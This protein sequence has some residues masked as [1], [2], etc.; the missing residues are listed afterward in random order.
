[1]KSTDF[2]Q[3]LS[4]FLGI[5]LPGQGG[6]SKNTI[7]SYRDSFTLLLRYCDEECNIS[8]RKIEISHISHTLVVNFLVW[9]E[10]VRN[11]S[12]STRNNR[13]AAIQSFFRYL[14][15]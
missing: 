1:M 14:A 13:L 11:S 10:N 5:Y 9:L 7:A 6:F 2:A 15:F 8:P 3:Q 12:I 4:Q